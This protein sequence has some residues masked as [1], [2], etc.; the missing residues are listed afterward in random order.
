MKR[1]FAIVVLLIAAGMTF[2]PATSWAQSTQRV[3][4]PTSTPSSSRRSRPNELSALDSQLSNA[5]EITLPQLTPL[6]TEPPESSDFHE[7]DYDLQLPL[8]APSK[9]GSA[10][11]PRDQEIPPE[12]D[13]A[14]LHARER[15]NTLLKQPGI[16]APASGGGTP[17]TRTV[18][19]PQRNSAAN[20]PISLTGSTDSSH[21]PTSPTRHHQK[22][23][24]SHRS[25]AP[26]R[27][28]SARSVGQQS[29]ANP[30]S[31]TTA[32]LAEQRMNV[33]PAAAFVTQ[34]E[35]D[36]EVVTP[37]IAAG[38]QPELVGPILPEPLW[39]DGQGVDCE[40]L[41]TRVARTVFFGEYLFL[42]PGDSEVGYAV[43]LAEPA[44]PGGPATQLGRTSVVE[45]DHEPGFRAGFIHG[46]GET[47]SFG[48]AYTHY[49]SAATS[50]TEIAGPN[51][52]R[53][54]VTHPLSGPEST[55]V[56]EATASLDVDFDLV[57]VE[58]RRL[59]VASHSFQFEL[60]LAARYGRLK[61]V[62]ESEF[63]AADV[64]SVGS[65]IEFNG[66]GFRVGGEIEGFSPYGW[67]LYGR[68][69]ASF[70]AGE[71]GGEFVQTTPGGAADVTNAW[72]SGR[73]VPILDVEFGVGWMNETGTL[74]A[75]AGY[76]FHGWFN[77]VKTDDYIAAVQSNRFGDLSG[78]TTF[79][80]LTARAEWR[81]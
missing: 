15:R 48:A 66:G 57:D 26:S 65:D 36:Y 3:S 74:R 27:D 40:C 51:I 52:L 70:L 19:A 1:R 61:Q 59:M 45:A 47:S 68:A 72:T 46:I 35:P 28:D 63:I 38:S 76:L 31:E 67:L 43:P 80:G 7:G 58:Y 71:F 64:T 20:H 23:P 2:R 9:P 44:V 29:D 69:G 78:T 5:V 62:F 50:Q 54:L 37:E 33:K 53:P 79:D 13:F 77:T 30:T 32:H 41:P 34:P 8:L 42:R 39:Y 60:S 25:D 6:G 12:F 24:D 17:T 21:A 73:V 75:S 11:T 55:D 49:E 56:G 14:A 81:Y 4:Q 16:V 10:V 18:S 22:L